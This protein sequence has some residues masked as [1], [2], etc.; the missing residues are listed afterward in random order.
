MHFLLFPYKKFL[1]DFP[2]FVLH[3]RN[4]SEIQYSVKKWTLQNKWVKAIVMKHACQIE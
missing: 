4:P 2:D 3:R 1:E